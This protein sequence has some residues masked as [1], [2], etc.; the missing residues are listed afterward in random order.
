MS[1]MRVHNINL[2]IHLTLRYFIRYMTGLLR[3]LTILIWTGLSRVVTVSAFAWS[4][5]SCRYYRVGNYYC[6]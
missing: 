5:L 3:R 6:W 4:V 1:V 2:N